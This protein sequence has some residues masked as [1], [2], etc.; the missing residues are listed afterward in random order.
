MKV[1]KLTLLVFDHNNHSV[2][3]IT[4]VFKN[5]DLTYVKVIKSEDRGTIFSESQYGP[6][7]TEEQNK[8]L[9]QSILRDL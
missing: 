8:Q 7:T 2:D 6:V 9:I 3:E 1:V 4:E 5:V